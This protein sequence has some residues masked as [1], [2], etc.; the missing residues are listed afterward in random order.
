MKPS[1]W[2]APLFK[3]DQRFGSR[4]SLS[5]RYTKRYDRS[6]TPF[7]AGNLHFGVQQADH[8]ML[9]GLNYTRMFNPATST[10]HG[11]I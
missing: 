6:L 3:I 8:Q 1:D 7:S 10:C 2:D 4:D 5:F 9:T 11:S